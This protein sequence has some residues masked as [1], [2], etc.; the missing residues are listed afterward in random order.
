[1]LRAHIFVCFRTCDLLAQISVGG[2]P[3]LHEH[4]VAVQTATQ[5]GNCSPPLGAYRSGAIEHCLLRFQAH[6]RFHVC[7]RPSWT[8]T[9]L[10]VGIT[11]TTTAGFSKGLPALP[12]EF[13]KRLVYF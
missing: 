12:T 1:M 7:L 9:L 2:R 8:S 11:P 10:A 13:T 3:L 5:P 4:E 6:M